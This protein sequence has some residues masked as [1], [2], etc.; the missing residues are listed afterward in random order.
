MSRRAWILLLALGAAIS[1]WGSLKICSAL[2]GPRTR[3][4]E[5]RR[6]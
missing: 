3:I 5:R 1:V 6:P 4:E 2:E